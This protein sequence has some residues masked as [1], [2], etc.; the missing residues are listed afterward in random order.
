M[1]D[2]REHRDPVLQ[3][4]E[5]GLGDFRR[6][7]PSVPIGHVA[8]YCCPWSGWVSLCLDSVEEEDQ[9]CPDFLYVEAALYQADSWCT[10]YEDEEAPRV[11]TL[12][13]RTVELDVEGEGDEAFN[14]EFFEFLQ[15]LLRTPR[16][17]A[18]VRAAAGDRARIGVQLLDS[19]FNDSW[20][21]PA[22]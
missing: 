13:G 4:L 11:T 16:A 18:A 6:S 1:I 3:F 12:A 2:L 15:A 8:L 19:E 14:R 21:L 20:S 7:H 10:E 17:E 5:A 9:N 22:A